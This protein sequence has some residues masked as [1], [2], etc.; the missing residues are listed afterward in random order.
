MVRGGGWVL[1]GGGGGG[2]GGIK[3]FHVVENERMVESYITS[4]GF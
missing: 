2:G 3:D 1:E 4:G